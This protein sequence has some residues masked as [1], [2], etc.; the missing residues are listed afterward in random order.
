MIRIILTLLLL[1]VVKGVVAQDQVIIEPAF[2]WSDMKNT[3]LQLMVSGQDISSFKPQ[4]TYDKIK[5]HDIVIVDNPNYLFIYLDIN[6]AEPGNFDI[7][8]TKGNEKIT[9]NYE[10][11]PRREKAADVVGFNSSD[12]VYLIMPDRFANGDP[13]NDQIKM[14]QTYQVD[15]S[16][17]TLRHGGD[18]LGIENQLDYLEQLG[19]TALWLTPVLEN[20]V[21][22]GSYHG[23]SITDH[24]KIDPR[25]GTNQD[26]ERLVEKAHKKGIK[27]IMDM[28][29]NHCGG[30]HKWITDKPTEDW[31]NNP[32]DYVETNHNKVFAFDPYASDADTKK[33][34]DGWFVPSMPDLNQKNP[35]LA[36]YLIQNSIWWI[37]YAG[38]DGIRQ[39]TYPY[40]DMDM[41]NDWCKAVDAEYPN[42]NIV[43]EIWLNNTPGAAAWQKGNK[44]GTELQ[45][46]MDFQLLNIASEA[47]SKEN[48]LY[49]IHEHL[50][51]DYLYSDILN[52][53]RFYD[54]HDATRLFPKEVGPG[55]LEKFKQAYTILLTIPGIPQ[56]FY[57]SEFMISGNTKKDFAYVRPEIPGGWEGD[58]KNYFKKSGFTEYQHQAWDFLQK[59]L[60]WRKGN[61]VIA[62]GAMKHFKVQ[63]GVYVYE[64]KLGNRQVLVVLNGDENTSVLPLVNYKEV[65]SNVNTGKDIITDKIIELKSPIKL[66]PKEVLILELE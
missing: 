9:Y 7:T 27:V 53:M 25:F 3:Q 36:K 30:N 60:Q 21:E 50:S 63:N 19:I 13:S 2:W 29:F 54:N 17:L 58:K 61:D 45:S 40:A 15:R 48:S 5:I 22:G 65:L 14:Q 56:L 35:H 1:A 10:L 62:N 41:M 44:L 8:F 49:K 59:L 64:R 12:V 6:G 51:Y 26:Y 43:G 39:D 24:Y 57:G 4:I 47:F 34:T 52:V 31:F 46:V 32:N 28:V 42:F 55:D 11:R 23:Y 18:L 16:D 33:M 37:E 20:D 38:L 66:G